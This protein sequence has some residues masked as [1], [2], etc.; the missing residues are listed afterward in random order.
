MN[1]IIDIKMI[2]E[3]KEKQHDEEGAARGALI[4]SSFPLDTVSH[5]MKAIIHSIYDF[6]KMR[7]L[8]RDAVR[9]GDKMQKAATEEDKVVAEKM[10]HIIKTETDFLSEDLW[11]V[12]YEIINRLEAEEKEINENLRKWEESHDKEADS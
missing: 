1:E 8:F 9:V 7:D 11:P 10:I 3:L 5:I 6:P 12:F 4:L 2:Q